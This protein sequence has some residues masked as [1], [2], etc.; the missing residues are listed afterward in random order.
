MSV[1]VRHTILLVDDDAHFREAIARR[2]RVQPFETLHASGAEEAL[3]VLRSLRVDLVVTDQK[4][5]GMQG[6]ELLAIIR[7]EFPGVVTILL[8]GE[9]DL[10]DT[11][12]AVNVGEV[13]RVFVKP[14]DADRLALSI[15]HALQQ[16]DLIQHARRLLLRVH[17]LEARVSA[18]SHDG[19]NTP[20]SAAA[21]AQT[22][23]D[24]AESATPIYELDDAPVDLGALLREIEATLD[25]PGKR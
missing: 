22:V 10:R 8:S 2:L 7:R 16:R 21:H 13:Y 20:P 23:A 4:M 3:A 18:L 24:L 6:T 1:A 15:R 14:Y 9:A 25:G 19:A 17:E 5:P 12:D 11:I